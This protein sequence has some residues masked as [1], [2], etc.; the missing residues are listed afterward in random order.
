M[1]RTGD[2]IQFEHKH[3][4]EELLKI[5]NKYVKQ[6]PKEKQNETLKQFFYLIDDI[7]MFW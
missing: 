5:I 2:T 6:N 3:E 4:V 1:Q 7:D